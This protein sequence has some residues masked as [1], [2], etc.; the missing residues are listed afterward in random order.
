MVL[1]HYVIR[2]VSMEIKKQTVCI[3]TDKLRNQ[4]YN[5]PDGFTGKYGFFLTETEL[6]ELIWDLGNKIAREAKTE[7]PAFYNEDNCAVNPDSIM[8]SIKNFLTEK[9]L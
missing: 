3:A 7:A 6:L 1:G 4:G 9:G 8:D 5:V 2:Q